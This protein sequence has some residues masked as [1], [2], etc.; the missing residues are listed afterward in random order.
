MRD[1]DNREKRQVVPN[2]KQLNLS[3]KKLQTIRKAKK[4]VNNLNVFLSID[5]QD[6][7]KFDRVV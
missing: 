4:A 2:N 3:V 5:K 6:K 1:I 7:T